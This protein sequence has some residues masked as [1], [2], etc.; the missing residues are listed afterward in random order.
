LKEPDDLNH[1]TSIGT[2]AAIADIVNVKEGYN[3]LDVNNDSTNEAYYSQWDRGSNSINTFY[4]RMK[5]LTRDGSSSTVYG[6]SGEL[7]RGITHELALNNTGATGTFQE[8]EAVSWSGGTG[9]L[10]AIDNTTASSATKMWIQLLTGTAPGTG[11]TITGGTSTATIATHGST[12]AVSRSIET[13]FVGASTGS[14][15]IGAYGVGL[16]VADLAATDKVKDLTDTVI[17]PPNTVVFSV[18]GLVV[19]EDRIL[20]GPW[21]GVT[22]D[23]EGNPA[24]QKSQ[25]TVSGGPINGAAV[26]SITCTSS[27]PS[28]TPSSGDIRIQLTSGKYAEVAYT[29]FTGSV[30]TINSTDISGDAI[31]ANANLWMAYLDKLAAST[32][33]SFSV[34]YSSDRQLVV[35]ARDGGATPIKQFISSAT[36]ASSGGSITVI[37][38]SD[39]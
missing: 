23:S 36:L 30:F 16:Q 1:Q 24:I 17:T 10:L 25:L 6:I 13:P 29:S 11:V 33:E 7:F 39:A 3:L 35:I 19:G 22:L 14:A 5:W 34:I 9:Q 32:T 21:D 28:D 2:I 26:T 31:P 12:T 15:L 8:P 37:R 20:V 38:T 27:I 18:S 4:E